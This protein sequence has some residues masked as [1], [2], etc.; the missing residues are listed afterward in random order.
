MGNSVWPKGSS[1]PGNDAALAGAKWLRT[2][3]GPFPRPS[4][5]STRLLGMARAERVFA[6]C[7]CNLGA[8][9]R[10]KNVPGA[11]RARDRRAYRVSVRRRELELCAGRVHLSQDRIKLRY[12]RDLWAWDRSDRAR[13]ALF[14]LLADLEAEFDGWL[15]NGQQRAQHIAGSV[16]IFNQCPESLHELL[17]IT[18]AE[19][20]LARQRSAH[21]NWYHKSDSSGC[22]FASHCA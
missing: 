13:Q 17:R 3:P 6:S 8:Y 10:F 4:Q 18:L 15:L 16:G 9:K 7:A 19:G 22:S 20:R 21:R 14:G 1:Q 2:A 12:G 11:R 5:A